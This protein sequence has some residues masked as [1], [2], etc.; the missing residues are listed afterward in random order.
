MVIFC[1]RHKRLCDELWERR[2]MPLNAE[3]RGMHALIVKVFAEPDARLLSIHLSPR[4]VTPGLGF[5]FHFDCH[6]RHSQP[7]AHPC[8][9]P[10]RDLGIRSGICSWKDFGQASLVC[11]HGHTAWSLIGWFYTFE[12]PCCTSFTLSLMRP[13]AAVAFK[14]RLSWWSTNLPGAFHSYASVCQWYLWLAQR[15]PTPNGGFLLKLIGDILVALSCLFLTL[16]ANPNLLN[17]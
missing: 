9:P 7:R 16:C 1:F 8:A 11:P 13:W 5:E 10:L 2:E 17:V 3:G 15:A 4:A 12:V 14:I 6:A